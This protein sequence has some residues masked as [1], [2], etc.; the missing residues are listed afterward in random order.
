M[1]NLNA[2]AAGWIDW[3]MLLWQFWKFSPHLLYVITQLLYDAAAAADDDEEEGND[4]DGRCRHW[5]RLKKRWRNS[6]PCYAKP[7]AGTRLLDDAGGPNHV[8]NV[9][10]SPLMASVTDQA[11]QHLLVQRCSTGECEPYR[12]YSTQQL[13]TYRSWHWWTQVVPNLSSWPA[14]I[15]IKYPNHF[16]TLAVM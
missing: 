3:N 7:S 10:D 13:Y 1:G 6:H 15:Y 5:I 14:I 2:G 9:C 12:S 16:Q 8:G 11:W 4:G